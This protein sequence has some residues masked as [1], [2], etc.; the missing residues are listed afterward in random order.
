MNLVNSVPCEIPKFKSL[1][2]PTIETAD[3]WNLDDISATGA[4]NCNRLQVYTERYDR[5]WYTHDF[6]TMSKTAGYRNH[7]KTSEIEA[8][9]V[10]ERET[11]SPENIQR[12][13]PSVDTHRSEERRVSTDA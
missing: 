5:L 2:H 13:L 11:L 1:G 9:E 12:T 10:F 7:I 8:R 3:I 4:K 6:E